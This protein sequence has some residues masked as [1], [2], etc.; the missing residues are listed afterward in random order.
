[1]AKADS[2]VIVDMAAADPL[3]PKA[4]SPLDTTRL[5]TLGVGRSDQAPGSRGIRI[6]L[7]RYL[8]D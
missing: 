1:M 5:V 2:Y 4:G 6:R 7:A 3:L 8:S